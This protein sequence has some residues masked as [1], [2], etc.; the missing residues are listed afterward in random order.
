MSLEQSYL[1]MLMRIDHP[2]FDRTLK[3]VEDID[4]DT[5]FNVI[6]NYLVAKQLVSFREAQQEVVNNLHPHTVTESGIDRWEE[7]YFGFT[8]PQRSFENRKAELIE[9]YTEQISMS[10]S[11]AIKVAEQITGQT[12][13]IV[14]SAFFSGWTLDDP[15]LSV[16]DKSTVLAG[17]N[18][19]EDSNL[20]IVVF[21]DPV[22]SAL[23]KRLDEE[24]TTI[25]KAGS[26][27]S[28]QAPTAFWILDSSTLGLDTV[29]G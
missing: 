17:E 5:P 16:L 11:D 4:A 24:L 26:R 29:L 25:E 10:K 1:D 28:I 3:A 19:A 14:F 20:Y 9:R 15:E 2:V 22:D 18:Q 7:T 13:G 23:L 21:S 6:F 27:H 12:P 8:K